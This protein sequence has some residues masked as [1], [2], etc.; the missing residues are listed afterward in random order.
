MKHQRVK[1]LFAISFLLFFSS[2]GHAAIDWEIKN[3]FKTD[4]APLDVAGSV[5]GKWTFVL[6]EGG[7]LLIYSTAD[8]TLA[9]TLQVDPS[10]DSLDVSGFQPANLADK[11]FLS[12][13]KTKTVQEILFEF[14]KNINIE[15]A[16]FLG[17]PD[18]PVTIVVFSDFE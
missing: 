8:G 5:D 9:D 3:T 4:A 12:S 16:P 10:M 14:I 2:L 15:G 1:Q 11:I 7:K 13:Q 18:A 6:T 17:P